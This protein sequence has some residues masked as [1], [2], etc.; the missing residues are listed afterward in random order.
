VLLLC[1]VGLTVGCGASGAA[2]RRDAATQEQEAQ[3][4]AMQALR[5]RNQELAAQVREL[6]ARL[7]L[8]DAELRELRAERAQGAGGVRETIRIQG[9]GVAGNTPGEPVR[10]EPQGELEPEPRGSRPVL[11]LY[12]TRR[13]GGDRNLGPVPQ[14]PPGLPDRLPVVPLPEGSMSG[15]GAAPAAGEDGASVASPEGAGQVDAGVR[16]YREALALVQRQ[17]FS[18][19][20]ARFARFPERFPGHARVA[21]A[22]YWR[23]EVLYALKRYAEALE[24]FVRVVSDRRAAPRV[25]ESLFKMGLCEKRLGRP[26]RARA[27]FERVQ[28]EFPDTV[29]ATMAAQEDAS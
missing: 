12:G 3:D 1:C 15:E 8:G 21:D 20:E 7:A 27:L 11:R 18:E 26:E 19:A 25:A 24:V 13:A 10:E 22:M 23:A 17:A 5:Q 14:V 6:D 9:R 28:R 29:A 2:A 4:Q 16:A